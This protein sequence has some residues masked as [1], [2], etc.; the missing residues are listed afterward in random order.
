MPWYNNIIILWGDIM[1]EFSSYDVNQKYDYIIYN[2][3]RYGQQDWNIEK[4]N[5]LFDEELINYL[6]SN[7]DFINNIN[8]IIEKTNM[9]TLLECSNLS[10]ESKNK[11]IA[12]LISKQVNIKELLNDNNK[13]YFLNYINEEYK[14]K[15]ISLNYIY[16]VFNEN[17]FNNFINNNQ[18]TST[19]V[20]NLIKN[21]C[22]YSNYDKNKIKALIGVDG[23]TDAIITQIGAPLFWE[24]VNDLEL[25]EDIIQKR[26]NGDS[27]VLQNPNDYT[28]ESIKNVFCDLYLHNNAKNC[29]FDIETILGY[30]NKSPEFKN[31]ISPFDTILSHIHTFLKKEEVFDETY[32][33]FINEIN[34]ITSSKSL[35]DMIDMIESKMYRSFENE[36]DNKLE[37]TKEDITK[38]INSQQ[39]ITKDGKFVPFYRIENQTESQRNFL[40]VNHT[41]SITNDMTAEQFYN[42]YINNGKKNNKLCVSLNNEGFIGGYGKSDKVNLGYFNTGN[43]QVLSANT[44]DGQTN[45][46]KI[47]EGKKRKVIK[48]VVLPIE[49]FMKDTYKYNEITL[50]NDSKDIEPVM[51]DFILTNNNE[52]TP[53]EVEIASTFG[54]PIYFVNKEKY[55]SY[56]ATSPRPNEWYDYD[57]SFVIESRVI[58]NEISN[59]QTISY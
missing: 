27:I 52:P 42:N 6:C 2:K 57:S 5:D 46:R 38:N 36:M 26:S 55:E 7:N 37:K 29:L 39:L 1:S 12:F 8:D 21:K 34:N 15:K 50:Y 43:K 25:S 59:S 53:I 56:E 4:F 10:L 20:I 23:I 41:T 19:E 24:L 22:N 58:E 48:N 11:L 28:S 17:E 31:D 33:N 3:Y 16:D 35:Y 47:D 30:M 9:N 54:I 13:N 40:F 49:D 32:S 45:Q 51:P 44:R 14:N 18:I